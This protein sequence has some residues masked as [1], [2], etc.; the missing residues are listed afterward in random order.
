MICQQGD[1]IQVCFDPSVGHEPNKYRPALVVSTDDFDIRSSLTAVC[2]VTSVDNG[3]PLHARIER[4][5]IVG[6]ACIEQLRTLDLSGRRC[7]KVGSA[8]EAEMGEVLA[9][10]GSVFG[11]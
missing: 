4:D 6:F 9:L 7:E 1:I 11:I 5:E 3:Y 2:P 10:I 8:S